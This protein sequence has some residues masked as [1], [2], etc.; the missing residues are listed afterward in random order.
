MPASAVRLGVA[1]APEQ[2]SSKPRRE[3]KGQEFEPEPEEAE[4]EPLSKPTG[5]EEHFRLSDPCGGCKVVCV[6]KGV[7]LID[8]EFAI[9][10]ALRATR[11]EIYREASPTLPGYLLAPANMYR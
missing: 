4:P 9:M 6:S 5:E 11:L 2:Y 10:H 3:E 7:C 8:Y 1:R